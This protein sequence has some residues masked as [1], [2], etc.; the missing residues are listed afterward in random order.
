MRKRLTVLRAGGMCATGEKDLEEKV[1]DTGLWERLHSSGA[2][3]CPT[4][5]SQKGPSF[6]TGQK[7]QEN[8]AHKTHLLYFFFDGNC[9]T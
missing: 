4:T 5:P 2:K 3:S 8:R 7:N 1:Q 6:L 9:M